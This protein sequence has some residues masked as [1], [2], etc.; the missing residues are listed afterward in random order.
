MDRPDD[1]TCGVCG[2]DLGHLQGEP[3][4]WTCPVCRSRLM[5]GPRLRAIPATA[6]MVALEESWTRN[7]ARWH[8]EREPLLVQTFVGRGRPPRFVAPGGDE[9]RI[10]H[11]FAILSVWLLAFL[12][13]VLGQALIGFTVAILGTMALQYAARRSGSRI[14]AYRL[15]EERYEAEKASLRSRA[16]DL[17]G[18]D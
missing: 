4:T 10:D 8:A 2:H 11:A 12:L 18:R 13:V 15:L 6:E 7:E 17:V 14:Q 5:L 9:D 3:F 16:W 1:W